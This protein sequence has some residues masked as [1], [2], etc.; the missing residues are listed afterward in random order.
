[1]TDHQLPED[2]RSQIRFTDDGLIP[3]IA[4]EASTGQVLMMAW[5][6]ETALAITLGTGEGTYW[7]RSRRELWRKGATSGHTQRVRRV[8]LDCDGDVVLLEV[9]QSG[10]ACHTGAQT[11]FTGGEITLETGA[12]SAER[13]TEH[14]EQTQRTE[15]APHTEQTQRTERTQEV[16]R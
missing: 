11:C 8:R 3:A 15:Q 4:Q 6:D 10:P 5:M 7:S 9:D 2:L 1:M 14:I 16:D 13:R 12:E